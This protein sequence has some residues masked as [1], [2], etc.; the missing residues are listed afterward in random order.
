MP[1]LL[2]LSSALSSAY[3]FQSYASRGPAPDFK[4]VVLQILGHKIFAVQLLLISHVCSLKCFLPGILHG[5]LPSSLSSSSL[6][7]LHLFLQ[8]SGHIG[9]GNDKL[10]SCQCSIMYETHLSGSRKYLRITTL[11]FSIR[12]TISP[13]FC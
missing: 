13:I 6:Q 10:D 12:A 2:F 4:N 8:P 7:A 5:K 11:C 9:S 3:H 1:S